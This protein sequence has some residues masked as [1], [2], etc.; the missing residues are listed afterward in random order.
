M[1]QLVPGRATG[2]SKDL[3]VF[4]QQ[5]TSDKSLQDVL[6]SK[7]TDR[8]PSIDVERSGQDRLQQKTRQ[9]AQALQTII[10]T[11]VILNVFHRRLA[12]SDGWNP[13]GTSVTDKER[14]QRNE[15]GRQQIQ[16]PL[17]H[18]SIVAKPANAALR[19]RQHGELKRAMEEAA[20][21][22]QQCPQCHQSLHLRAIRSLGRS[23]PYKPA[24]SWA[25]LQQ[26][27]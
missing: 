20:G 15:T 16:E 9:S 27:Q 11:V 3:H 25:A 8:E 23:W 24:A 1:I 26:L 13:L 17:V 22:G 5:H 19:L 4:R 14:L 21:S 10:L 2:S 6:K 18:K 12:L 7:E